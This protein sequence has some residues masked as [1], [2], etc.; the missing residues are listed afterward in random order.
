MQ[1]KEDKKQSERNAQNTVKQT[2]ARSGL[3]ENLGAL[4]FNSKPSKKTEEKRAL[5]PEEKG[6]GGKGKAKVVIND[7]DFPS[8]WSSNLNHYIT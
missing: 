2:D 1:T 4:G 7:D 3:D 8:L 5:K 6:K